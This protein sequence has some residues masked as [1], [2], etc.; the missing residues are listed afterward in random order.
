MYQLNCKLNMD[1]YEN[2]ITANNTSI[3]CYNQTEPSSYES[4]TLF[5]KESFCQDERKPVSEFI[6]SGVFTFKNLVSEKA[7]AFLL[8]WSSKKKNA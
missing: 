2:F 4:M 8:L 3:E 7:N 6:T 5:E 1:T